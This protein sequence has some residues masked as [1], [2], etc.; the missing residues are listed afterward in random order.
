MTKHNFTSPDLETDT[1]ETLSQKLMQTN[2]KLF[3]A[4]RELTRL[5]KERS[6][7]LANISHDL[8]A[9]LTAIRSAID[10]LLSAPP[11]NPE[12]LQ[13]MLHM[14]DRRTTVLESLIHDMHLLFT[15][16]NPDS[17]LQFETIDAAPFLESYFFDTTMSKTFENRETNLDMPEDL[18]ALIRIDV[19]KMIR[20]L[21]N[22]FTN[23]AKYAG[24][25]ASITLRVRK[26]ALS[27]GDALTKTSANPIVLPGDRSEAPSAFSGEL[28]QIEVIDTGIGIPAESLP[29][30]FSRTYTVSRARTPGSPT[31]SGLGLCIVQ[32]LIERFGG[33]ITCESTPGVST[34]FRILLPTMKE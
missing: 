29:H 7:M 8:R 2:L 27:Q 31:G 30:I 10:L 12:Q 17:P 6:E 11:E 26:A 14:M 34:C 16:E 18:K 9:P 3:E 4:N 20:V 28:L 22:L 15:V 1:I 13:D 19:Q 23:A 24:E 32:T 33:S 5:Q 21:D 25:D